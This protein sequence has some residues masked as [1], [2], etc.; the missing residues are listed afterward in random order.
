ME[1]HTIKIKTVNSATILQR[2]IQIVKRRRINIREF[3]ARQKDDEYG[4][5]VITV[6]ADAEQVRKLRLQFERQVDVIRTG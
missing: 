1:L 3:L 6:E 2:V 4:I 5:I